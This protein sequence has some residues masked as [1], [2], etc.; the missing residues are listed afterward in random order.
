MIKLVNKFELIFCNWTHAKPV[1][2]VEV[3]APVRVTA[4]EVHAVRAIATDL[5][6]APTAAVRACVVERAVVVVA[7]AHCR[8]KDKV[9]FI[10]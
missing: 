1:V 4:V 10:R 5:R 6:T 2:T 7:I 8:Q 9:T 3:A